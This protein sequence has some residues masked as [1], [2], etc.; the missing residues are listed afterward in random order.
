MAWIE[1]TD[2]GGHT[3]Y[4]STEQMVRIRPVVVGV[5]IASPPPSRGRSRNR[6]EADMSSALAIADL[7]SGQQA[8]RETPEEI[9]KRI[10]AAH[11][12]EAQA[13]GA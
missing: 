6:K 8:V 9:I 4:L 10:R 5:D 2:S 1:V 11:R 3:V 12:E 7:T 13:A